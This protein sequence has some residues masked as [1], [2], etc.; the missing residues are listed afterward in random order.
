MIPAPSMQST[1]D[2]SLHAVV[3]LE[4]QWV[5]VV[6]WKPPSESSKYVPQKSLQSLCTY[7]YQQEWWQLGDHACLK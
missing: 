1:L 2:R 6:E 3:L 7:V 4:K 5:M